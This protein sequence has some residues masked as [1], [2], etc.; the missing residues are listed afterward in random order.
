MSSCC[1]SG[2]NA[3]AV[4]ENIHS[5]KSVR[6]YTSEPV[7][8]SDIQTILKAAMA[9]PSAV[10]FQPWRFVVVTERE[11]LDAMAEI[12]PYAKML[13]QAP[14][15]IVV[16][17]ETLWMGG[18]ENPYWQQDCAAA[19]QNLLLA[20]EALGLGAVW[21]GVYPNQDLYPKLHNYLNLPSTVQ[22]FCCIPVGHPAGNEQPKDKWK[23]ENIHYGKW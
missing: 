6:Q 17:G 8:E 23:P 15:A 13:R 14:A 22:P 2:S 9:A 16:C 18:N 3:D 1:N 4:L 12:L 5:R 21:T 10:N 11:Q 7:S 19:T 20:V